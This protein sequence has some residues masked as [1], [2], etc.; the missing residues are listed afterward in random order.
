RYR[1]AG[2]ELRREQE[3]PRHRAHEQRAHVAHFAVVDHGQRGLHAVEQLDQQHQSRRDVDFVEYVGLVRRDDGYAEDLP[4]AGGEDEKPDEGTNQCGHEALA[5]MQE[6][7][8]FAPNDPLEAD[9]VLDRR[10]SGHPGKRGQ[11][12]GH[13]AS[14]AASAPCVSRVK[15]A[16]ISLAPAASST[17]GTDPCARTHPWC[18]TMTSSSSA[19]SSMRWVAHSTEAPSST[20]SR[21]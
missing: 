21:R 5:L 10:K 9:R 16:R 19:T 15:A 18:S 7:Q 8:A 11:F 20:T 2:D 3:P 14:I 12:D 17:R 6:A 1:H 4:K 13:G